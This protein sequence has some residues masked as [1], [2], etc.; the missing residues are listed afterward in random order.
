MSL[1]DPG[2]PDAASA[3][4]RLRFETVYDATYA[5]VLRFAQRR[6]HPSHAE[7]VAA[8]VFV[9][10][11]RR[12]ADVPREPDEARAWLFGVARRLLLA[13]QRA[14]QRRHALTLRIADDQV[15]G[16]LGSGVDADL[17]LHHV[18]LA[19]AWRL[20]SPVHQESLALVVWDDLT[21]PQAAEVLGISAVAFRLRL[22]R[23][24]RALR[25]HLE[26]GTSPTTTTTTTTTDRAQQ[27]STR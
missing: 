10:A 4:A 2:P 17:V 14:D 5:A 25:R 6:V 27:R 3:A 26:P 13:S 23:A 12:I 18:D 21:S 24:R 20:L 19:R 22:S 11:W 7:D 1:S 9:V 16:R 8:D 15:T